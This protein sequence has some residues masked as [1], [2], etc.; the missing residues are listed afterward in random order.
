MSVSTSSFSVL[1]AG[2]GD[3]GHRIA[4][5]LDQRATHYQLALDLYAIRRQQEAHPL[6]KIIQ[7]DMTQP[8]NTELPKVDYVIF[9]VSADEL[10][11]AGYQRSYVEGQTS[12]IQSRIRILRLS[13]IF[14]VQAPVCTDRKIMN[15]SMKIH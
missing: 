6:V 10:T 12:L 11:E 14:S 13:T 3:I 2:F 1:I 5:A 9:C 7:W 8:I 15:G 4:E